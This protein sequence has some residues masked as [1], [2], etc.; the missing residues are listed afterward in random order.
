MSLHI[1]FHIAVM[2][3]K[4]YTSQPASGGQRQHMISHTCTLLY[5]A[6]PNAETLSPSAS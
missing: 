1:Y 2:S 3:N 4:K 6:L 5:M